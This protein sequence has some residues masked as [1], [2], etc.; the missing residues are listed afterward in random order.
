MCGGET[1]CFCVS[2][3]RGV[4]RCVGCSVVCDG[5]CWRGSCM[6]E[7][8]AE[9]QVILGTN[10]TPRARLPK[11]GTR[12]VRSPDELEYMFYFHLPVMRLTCLDRVCVETASFSVWDGQMRY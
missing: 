11:P 5:D 12:H 2:R 3:V 4:E 10:A 8:E 1:L 9:V 7:V 6:H